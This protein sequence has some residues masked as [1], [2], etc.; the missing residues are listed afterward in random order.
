[1]M[2]EKKV[3]KATTKKSTSTKN[4]QSTRSKNYAT[5]STQTNKSGVK[6]DKSKTATGNG[7][8]KVA[9]TKKVSKNKVEKKENLALEEVTEKIVE[10]VTVESE[11]KDEKADLLEKTLVFDGIQNKNIRDVVEKLEEDKVVL[12]D[13]VIKRSKVKKA[14]I[15]ILTLLMVIIGV[16]TTIYILDNVVEES[17]TL[18]SNV[19]KKAARKYRS[20]KDI[21]DSSSS[22]IEDIDY[23]GVQPIT[24]AEFE[25]KAL[26]KEDMVVLVSNATCYSCIVFEPTISE[27]FTKLDKTIYKINLSNMDEEEKDLFRSYYAFRGTPTIF[28]VKNGIVTADV[29]GTMTDEE[30]IEWVNDNV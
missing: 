25:K 29:I 8:K 16:V 23:K 7:I 5:K 20:E 12:E 14:F 19:Y 3:K 2:E 17:E 15:I 10:P 18:N 28:V 9:S 11:K 13:K 30:L 1:M 22:V 27:V 6:T 24:L 26:K 4:K 21:K